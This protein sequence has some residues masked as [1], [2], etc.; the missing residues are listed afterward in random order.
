MIDLIE[1]IIEGAAIGFLVTVICGLA[2]AFGG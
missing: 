2:I 1:D